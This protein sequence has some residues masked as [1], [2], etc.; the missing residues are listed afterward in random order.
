[1]TVGGILD[2][3]HRERDAVECNRTL[4]RDK[5]PELPRHLEREPNTIAFRPPVDNGGKTVDMTVD[6]V[7]SEPVAQ[8]QR[9]LQIDQRSDLPVAASRLRDRK[10][11]R[12]NSS[13]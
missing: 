4:R 7:A 2:L 3:V 1:M 8:P 12:L 9:L 6:Q 13:N 5:A 11:T 10:R